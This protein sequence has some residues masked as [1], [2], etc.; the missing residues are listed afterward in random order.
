MQNEL[1]TPRLVVNSG[2]HAHFVPAATL[3]HVQLEFVGPRLGADIDVGMGLGALRRPVRAAPRVI[4]SR[5]ALAG[6]V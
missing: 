5:G 3:A 2:R 4:A 6:A 1:L